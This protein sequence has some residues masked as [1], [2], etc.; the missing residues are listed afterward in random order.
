M[1]VI[2]ATLSS[3]SALLD[4]GCSLIYEIFQH[5]WNRKPLPEA[6]RVFLEQSNVKLNLSGCP[7][8]AS[9]KGKDDKKL[10]LTRTTAQMSLTLFGQPVLQTIFPHFLLGLIVYT[11]LDL[12]LHYKS[13]R[14][15]GVYWLFPFCRVSSGV[16]A[17]ISCVIA[18][19]V[20]VGRKKE[21]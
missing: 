8:A 18:K 2:R 11:T 10:T 17:A 5:L 21:G 4:H 7:M 9:F 3:H 6:W 15:A 16:L 14:N 12:V 20:L 19:W 1:D 13:T